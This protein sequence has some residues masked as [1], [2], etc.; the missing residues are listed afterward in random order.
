[1]QNVPCYYQKIFCSWYKHLSSSVSVTSAIISQFL[2]FNN[3]KYMLIEKQGFLFPTMS[4]NGLNYVGQLLD[5]NGET[6]DCE[7]IKL[8]F[9]LENKFYFSWM[10]MI[11]SIPLSWKINIFND[12]GK[13]IN[14]CIFE[15]HLIKNVESMKLIG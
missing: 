5:N 14:L 15:C 12:K 13:S 4:N 10:Q 2:W 8:E 7:T 9:N 11:D 3:N 6:K 1:M